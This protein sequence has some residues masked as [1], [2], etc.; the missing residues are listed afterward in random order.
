M[1]I[2]HIV[3]IKLVVIMLIFIIRIIVN[4][5]TKNLVKEL[6]RTAYT[7]VLQ[8]RKLVINKTQQH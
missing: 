3:Y 7:K 8:L 2:I 1:I 6:V 4:N 5:G